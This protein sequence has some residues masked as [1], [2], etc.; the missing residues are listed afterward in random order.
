M[1]DPQLVWVL[2]Q[3]TSDGEWELLDVFAELDGA[4]KALAGDPELIWVVEPNGN[5]YAT[6][7]HDE[8]QFYLTRMEVK[9]SPSERC[10][11]TI[12]G[13]GFDNVSFCSLP[14]G[15]KGDHR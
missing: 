3:I 5:L 8:A 12:P 9:T 4:K 2:E 11:A 15:H 1:S 13:G 6:N 14:K 10:Y 7:A